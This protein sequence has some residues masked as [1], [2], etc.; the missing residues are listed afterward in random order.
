MEWSKITWE[1]L[2]LSPPRFPVNINNNMTFKYILYWSLR[3]QSQTKNV[4]YDIEITFC[5]FVNVRA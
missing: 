5:E 4:I 2:G 3:N 1:H